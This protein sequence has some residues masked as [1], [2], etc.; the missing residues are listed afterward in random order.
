ML[1]HFPP[2]PRGPRGGGAGEG[3]LP[4]GAPRGFFRRLLCPVRFTLGFGQYDFRATFFLDLHSKGI[5]NCV[6]LFNFANPFLA[7]YDKGKLDKQF[8]G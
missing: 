4:R 6:I 1:P 3:G 7:G 8:R 2:L 5:F